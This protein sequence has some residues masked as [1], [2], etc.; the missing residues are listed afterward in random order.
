MLYIGICYV[1]GVVVC[2]YVLCIFSDYMAK[3]NE[4]LQHAYK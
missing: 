2:I 4:L 3:L 1:R